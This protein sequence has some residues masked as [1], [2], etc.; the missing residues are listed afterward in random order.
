MHPGMIL[1]SNMVVETC[2]SRDGNTGESKDTSFAGGKAFW[3]YMMS[4]QNFNF[5]FL[6]SLKPLCKDN[7]VKVYLVCKVKNLNSGMFLLQ[8]LVK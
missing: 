5:L 6:S 2:Y 3:C 7:S 8:L 1:V 4:L